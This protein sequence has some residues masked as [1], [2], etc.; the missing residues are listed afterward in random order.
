MA[1]GLALPHVLSAQQG[2]IVRGT[3]L[4][5]R[6]GAPLHS[7]S[8]RRL[9]SAE[10][11]V[12]AND[13]GRF[14]I[15]VPDSAVQL[16]AARLGFAPDT[17]FVAAGSS[18]VTFN[19][20]EAALELDPLV[21]TAEPAF[22][23]AS[24][25]TIRELDLALRPVASAQALLPL[26]PGLFIAQHAGGG[27]A[28]QIFLRGFDADHGTDVAI[29]VDGTPI[30]MV[31]HAHGQGYAD[32]HF[33]LPEVV[34]RMNVRKGPY[35]AQDGDLA[36]AG[37]IDFRTRDRVLGLAEVRGGNFGTVRGVAL[38][39]FG[40]DATKAGGY[41]G[42]AYSHTEGPYIAPQNFNS[43]NGTARFTAPLGRNT[44]ISATATGYGASWDASGQVPLRAIDDGSLDRFGSI[45]AT[46]GGRTHRYEASV[47]L[48]GEG[49]DGS[50][51]SA[52][53]YG[54]NYYLNLFSNFTFFLVDSTN[55]DGIEQRDD[56]WLYGA[57][58][59]YER[60]TR[61]G[62]VRGNLALGASLRI[63]DAEVALFDQVTR[64]RLDT[65]IAN[66][67]QQQ[68]A[69]L[70]ARQNLAFG[71]RV[72]L[73]LGL[74]GDLFNVRVNTDNQFAAGVEPPI[75]GNRTL[76]RVSPKASLAVKVDRYTTLYA[77]AGLGFHSNDARDIVQ[78]TVGDNVLP[79]AF[80]AE[81]GVRQ[82][83]NG[84][85][86]AVAGWLLNLQS[87]LVFVGDEG[88][89]EAAGPS[90]RLGIDIEGRQR[91][92]PWLWFDLDMN[93]ARGELTEEPEGANS[94]A[95]APT[96]TLVAGLALRNLGPLS[97]GLRM[98]HISDRPAAEDN[99]VVAQGYTVTQL[100]ATVDIGRAQL[101]TSVENLFDVEWN[102][103]QFATT[104]RLQGEPNRGISDLNFTPGAPF[105][106]IVGLRWIF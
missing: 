78:G 52:R 84:G 40:G 85:S 89:T 75:S 1:G 21:V 53:A 72:T 95:L 7:A 66:T 30:N 35:A 41:I 64:T 33:L 81:L 93:L 4:G 77:N 67:I 6:D 87:E 55:G 103:A 45:D 88:V 73:Q 12:L 17:M 106:V 9:G 38:V 57:L 20:R 14:S 59:S 94:I 8:V 100:F 99:S 36:T 50:Q 63:D 26:V 76:G 15:A 54:V 32:V 79:A 92:L 69:S 39:P 29:K 25:S 101:F 51:W 16:V 62:S 97:G 80:G 10:P 102:E 42:G 47:A 70:W 3:V 61:Y 28:E 83:W 43:G 91:I 31:S 46:E 24:S 56:R 104:S 105:G 34:E 19:L 18:E 49:E 11:P 65:R 44:R 60:P 74:R 86:V 98:R 37:A 71:Q 23:A 58:G 5:T 2:R 27:K 68:N 48:G 82:S 90:Q 22:S 13:R 96:F